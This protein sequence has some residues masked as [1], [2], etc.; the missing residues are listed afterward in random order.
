MPG[1]HCKRGQ[2]HSADLAAYARAMAADNS[3]QLSRLKRNLLRALEEDITPKQR[4]ALQMYYSQ[5]LNMRQISEQ[6][7][8]NKSTVCRTLRR[9]EDRLRRCL[10]YGAA[11]LLDEVE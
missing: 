1:T 7:G 8:V 9:G 6:L 2:A 10:R 4:R 3:A 11:S 5:G